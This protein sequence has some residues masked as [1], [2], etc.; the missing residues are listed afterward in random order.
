[1]SRRPLHAPPTAS[2]AGADHQRQSR[3]EEAACRYRQDQVHALAR[4]HCGSDHL[5]DKERQED[6]KS[7]ESKGEGAA[8]GRWPHTVADPTGTSGADL[9]LD[10][11]ADPADLLRRSR[12]DSRSRPT[13]DHRRTASPRL[14]DQFRA[15]VALCASQPQLHL[16]HTVVDLEA[17]ALAVAKVADDNIVDQHLIPHEAIPPRARL[18]LHYDQ[19]HTVLRT[20]ARTLSRRSLT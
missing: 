13:H 15:A 6:G 4:P 17:Y 9:V 19:T 18:T 12:L 2:S 14:N 10:F 3:E 7:G 11:R 1:V 20:N 8:G 16:V 5:A